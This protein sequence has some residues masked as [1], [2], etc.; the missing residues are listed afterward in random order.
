MN[1][2]LLPAHLRK[3]YEL[4]SEI[5]SISSE[6]WLYS[7][8]FLFS[9]VGVY[10][11]IKEIGE[12]G[13]KYKVNQLFKYYLTTY[14]NFLLFVVNKLIFFLIGNKVSFNS[15][16]IILVDSYVVVANILKGNNILAD[17]YPGLLEIL[18]LERIQYVI[19][20]RFY[21]SKNPY[22][23]YQLFK[24]WKKKKENVV[25]EYQ[26]IKIFDLI[27]IFTVLTVYPFYMLKLLRSL[28]ID[29]KDRQAFDFLIWSD[30][31]GTNFFGTIRYF[32]GKNLAPK[33]GDDS[34][35]IQWYEGQPFEKCFNRALREKKIPIK[36]YGTQLFLYPPELLNAYIDENELYSH[37]PDKILVNGDY[38][39]DNNH[40][41]EVGPSIRYS[42]LFKY[43]IS[44]TKSREVLVL[45]SYFFESNR[46]ILNLLREIELGSDSDIDFSIKLH[47]STDFDS[48]AGLFPKKYKL[49]KENIYDLFTTHSLVLGAATGAQVEAIA[50]GIPVVLVSEEEKIDYSYLPDFCR[51]ILWD[52]ASDLQSFQTVKTKLMN[53]LEEN[54][55]ERL[56]IIK[57][58]RDELFCEPTIDTITNA[59]ELGDYIRSTNN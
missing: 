29:K 54:N 36:I 19:I 56:K 1:L 14:F 46:I 3:Y 24:A 33:I 4:I 25:T 41:I 58:V 13:I 12:I 26:V 20:P 40:K 59:F 35:L 9:K 45:L 10:E 47:P 57:K 16:K 5:I 42:R 8:S 21:G 55:Q 7:T 44:N 23:Y 18:K 27:R 34:K 32:F 53:Q 11:R 30:I 37:L 31:N 49:V 6:S 48:I 28:G 52:M 50:C 39:R 15:Q 2:N 22:K 43:E 38:Y 17:Y 51:G